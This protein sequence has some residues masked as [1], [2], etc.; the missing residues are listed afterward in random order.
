M[1][2]LFASIIL[3][4]VTT[5][6]LAATLTPIQLLNPAGSTSGQAILSTGPTTAPIW[7]GVALS[8]VTGTLAITNGGTGATSAAAARTNLGAAA[9]SS[10]LSQ[11]A[12][13]TSAQLAAIVSDESGSGSLLFGTSPTLN[14]PVINGVTN[15]S[16]ALAGSVGEYVTATGTGVSMS[17][18]VNNTVASIPLSAGDWDVWGNVEFAQTGGALST[19]L[20]TSISQGSAS[21]ASAPN[22]AVSQFSTS[23]PQT[24]TPPM[25]RVS[26]A[27]SSTVFL[28]AVPT[29][30]GG[31]LT[32]TGFIAARR[33]H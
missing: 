17:S 24:V 23:L 7:G 26:I 33:R 4:F 27:G 9:T 30:T 11:F 22:R 14:Q 16:N 12:T 29:F 6:A 19:V 5:C 21:I 25:Q 3:S 31:T 13:T 15:G 20:V 10:P 1:K 2:R 18:G 28:M 8:G 32:A